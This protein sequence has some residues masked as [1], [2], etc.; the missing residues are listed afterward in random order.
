MKF[1]EQWL[2]TLVDPPLAT[3]EL[4]D[5]LTMAGL[6]VEQ[7]APAAPPFSGVVVARIDAVVPHPNADRLRVCTVD[8]GGPEPLQI[9]CGAPNAAAGMHVPCA[10]EGAAL[11]GGVAIKRTTM[12]GVESRGMLCS[13]KELGIADDDAG[14]LAL[15]PTLPVGTPVREALAL[16][17]TI[18]T[19]KLTPNRADCLSLA[20]I[21]REVAAITGASLALPEAAESPV[22]HDAARQ[23]RVEDP[24]ACPRFVVRLIDGIDAKAPTPLW[25][26]QRLERSGIRSISA[27]VDIT[28]YVMLEL[29]QPLHA[30][31]DR[32]LD[33][34]IVVR[35]ARD[36]EE[37]VLL[38]GQKLALERDLLLICD[39]RKPLGLAGIMGGEHSGIAD[40]TTRVCLEGA[41]FAPAV[42]QGKMRRLGFVS[43]A[44]HRF[45]RGVD[46][47]GC[48]RAVERATQLI[49]AI[50]GGK[51]GPLT[52]VSTPRE[53]PMRT[54]VQVR[55]A[56][57]AR[58]LGVPLPAEAISD[59]F[60]RLRFAFTRNAEGFSVTPPSYRFDLAIEE[61]FVEE[62]ARLAGYEHITAE[63]AP[64]VQFML[65]VPERTRSRTAVRL[66]LA[67]RAWHEVV[68]FSFVA[69]ADETAIAGR[70]ASAA[71]AGRVLNPLA[72][73]LDVMRTSL[74]P[75][76]IGVLRT[77]LGRREPIVR[78]F[79]LGR[80]FLR[81]GGAY[82]QPMRLGGL[83]FG[84]ATSE[85]WGEALR[86]GDFFDVKGDLEALASPLSLATATT[87]RPALH[88]GRSA[89]IAIDGRQVGW[90]GELHPR[91]ARHFD[92]PRAPVVFEVDADALCARPT[93]VGRPVS[94]QPIVRRDM[95]LVVDD[96]VPAGALLA[97]LKSAKP[98]HV[99]SLVLFDVYQGP[100]LTNGKKSLAI[101]VLMQ[102]TSRTL[103]DAEIDATMNDLMHVAATKFGATLRR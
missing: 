3:A 18:I 66:A 65:P 79:E 9:V 20:G 25:M 26:R 23:V 31:D 10:L 5:R 32:L 35:F 44:G 46:F 102:D 70:D 97:A 61:D 96:G 53:Y 93:R 2:R 67:A 37:L 22:T 92:L 24:D 91:L 12:R 21:A 27:I 57:V 75:G 81:D 36:G 99:E 78:I 13:A 11:P 68:T 41:F 30:Y 45:E 19:L 60:A 58:L 64:H 100:G 59:A 1:S 8:T 89:S 95:A 71:P 77:N 62:A 85:Q 28:N 94:R 6:E 90:M 101:L 17:D 14:L 51:A 43:D 103:T 40:D 29:G 86:E 42:I 39:E 98:A 84:P 4:A 55:T 47:A 15:A 34:D 73:H 69:A 38:N 52:D 74:L 49:I 63:P 72:S 48:A 50:C 76:L 80:V 7:L 83:A 56:R 16:D 33:G 82:A 54:P 88:P 87:S